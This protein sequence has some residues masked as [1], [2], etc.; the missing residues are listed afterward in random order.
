MTTRRRRI[1]RW[2]YRNW[3]VVAL[4]VLL[5]AAASAPA[6]WH[7]AETYKADRDNLQH[8]LASTHVQLTK[9]CEVLIILRQHQ[10]FGDLVSED[11]LPR[12][13]R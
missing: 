1:T 7:M 10:N 5:L 8:I 4:V 12:C 11:D 2:W 9:A 3:V 13:A 6:S